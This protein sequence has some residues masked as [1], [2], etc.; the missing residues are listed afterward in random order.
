MGKRRKEWE[1][2]IVHV[3][4]CNTY[5]IITINS[6]FTHTIYSVITHTQLIL[7]TDTLLSDSL[8]YPTLLQAMHPQVYK[9]VVYLV[10]SLARTW[11]I[12]I[13]KPV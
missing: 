2:S 6:S 13:L 11:F 7:L 3:K 12:I 4:N 5:P 8:V 1:K 9:P 10:D